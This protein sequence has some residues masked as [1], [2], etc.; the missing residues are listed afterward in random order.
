ME[1]LLARLRPGPFLTL[2]AGL[3]SMICIIAIK[4]IRHK[5]MMWR[6]TRRERYLKAKEKEKGSANKNA[7]PC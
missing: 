3:A 7:A 5:G 6:L 2:L 4:V 1:P